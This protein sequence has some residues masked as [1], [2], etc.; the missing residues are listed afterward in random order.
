ME[1]SWQCT[2]LSHPRNP[3]MHGFLAVF[4]LDI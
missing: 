4:P 2:F 3:R 1:K